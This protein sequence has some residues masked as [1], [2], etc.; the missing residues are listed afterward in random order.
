MKHTVN[1]TFPSNYRDAFAYEEFTRA[2]ETATTFAQ[3]FPLAKV[4]LDEKVISPGGIGGTGRHA[5]GLYVEWKL[6]LFDEGPILSVH[7]SAPEMKKAFSSSTKLTGPMT[8]DEI[9]QA[10]LDLLLPLRLDRTVAVAL[11]HVISDLFPRSR[12]T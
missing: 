12:R 6:C 8:P 9:D 4:V 2:K 5:S 7:A 3:Y 1:V 11:D 10:A